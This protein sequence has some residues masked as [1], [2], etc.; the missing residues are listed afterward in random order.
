MPV[1]SPRHAAD[2]PDRDIDCQ[3]ALEEGFNAFID[4][5]ERAGWHE[6]EIFSAMA[7]L[8]WNRRLAREAN[9]ETDEAVRNTRM[10]NGTSSGPDTS[11]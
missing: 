5:A 7:Y 1:S 2:Y 10:E 3:Q 11:M 8:A 4:E 9:A 6:D